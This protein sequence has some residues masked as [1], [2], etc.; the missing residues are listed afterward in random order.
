MASAEV[1]KSFFAK[2]LYLFRMAHGSTRARKASA[3]KRPGSKRWLL[4]VAG[5]L[6]IAT[7][8]LL[9]PS[10]LARFSAPHDR[11]AQ[12]VPPGMCPHLEIDPKTGEAR[13]KGLMPCDRS[14]GQSRRIDSIREGFKSH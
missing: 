6:G 3:R 10:L 12:A 9:T 8:G 13:D 4:A 11:E 7:A 5:V 1:R 14:Y 2:L